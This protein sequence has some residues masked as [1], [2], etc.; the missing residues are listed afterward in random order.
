MSNS[1]VNEPAEGML[2]PTINK[3][4][5]GKFNRYQLAVATA[6][7]AR[8]ITD[9]YVRERHIA[10]KNALGVKEI[11]KSAESIVNPDYRDRKAVKIAIDKID[12]GEY[13]IVDL[14]NGA[15]T[16]GERG[17]L[18][19]A[20]QAGTTPSPKTSGAAAENAP[21]EDQTEHPVADPVADPV[22][23]PTESG[24]E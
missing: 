16:L 9:E 21:A 19:T 7:C 12:S 17:T 20:H 24:K 13:V 23:D 15:M 22:T 5:K 18:E 3:L 14:D 2:H 8:L 6:K 1:T 11:E 10:E 4:T